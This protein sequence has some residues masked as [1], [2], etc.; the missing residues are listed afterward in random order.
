ML[1]GGVW[2]ARPPAPCFSLIDLAN[3]QR[4]GSPQPGVQNLRAEAGKLGGPA[5]VPCLGSRS[6]EVGERSVSL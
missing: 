5:P 4:D 3:E 6:L 2:D 1:L